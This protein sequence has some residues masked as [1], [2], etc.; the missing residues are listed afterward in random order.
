M[1]TDEVKIP[2]GTTLRMGEVRMKK[3]SQD[4]KFVHTK[5]H[6]MVLVGKITVFSKGLKTVLVELKDQATG[7]TME[8]PEE[9][10]NKLFEE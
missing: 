6:S 2:D 8:I 5:E 4:D 1:S 7:L 3:D 9:I 10:F